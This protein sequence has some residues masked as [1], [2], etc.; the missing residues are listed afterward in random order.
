MQTGKALG[1]GPQALGVFTETI[2][3]SKP[4]EYF[5]YGRRRGDYGH[6]RRRGDFGHG[7]G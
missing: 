6:G 5:D 7:S 3:D 4:R 1:G 2:L